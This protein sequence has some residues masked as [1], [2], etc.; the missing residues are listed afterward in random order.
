[1]IL[2]GVRVFAPGDVILQGAP[3]ESAGYV[4]DGRVMVTI[5]VPVRVRG[6]TVSFQTARGSRWGRLLPHAQR[7]GGGGSSSGDDH[8][9]DDDRVELRDQLY[10]SDGEVWGRG[11]H[12]FLFR[13]VLAGD[14]GETMFTAHKR[15]AYEVRAELVLGGALGG[16]LGGTLGGARRWAAQ[17]VAVKRVPFFGPAWEF[18]ASDMVHVSAVWRSR[19]EMCALGCSRVQRDGR[20]LRVRGVVRALEKGFR[21]TR[22]GFLLEER[23]RSRVGRA[24]ATSSSTIAASRY[25][26]A[27]EHGGWCGS[28]IVDQMAFDVELQI[29][30]AY[31]KIQYD[32]KHGPVTVSHRLAFVVA[33]VDHLG[34]GTSLRLFTP[35]HI[36]PH[37]CAG[38]GDELPAY[39]DAL[40]DR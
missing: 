12:E 13:I 4:L 31:G 38:S 37:D 36:M 23:T 16:A 20:P 28:P 29:P 21:L 10:S 30:K 27:G 7:G 2:P 9:H 3:A 24:P 18:L 35:L 8:D 11:R 17:A 22:V 1:M 15:V 14:L 32:V 19:I 6:L 40:A 25:L 39:A 34:R 26:R 33:V 5:R